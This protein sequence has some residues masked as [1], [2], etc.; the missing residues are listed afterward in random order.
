MKRWN[1]IYDQR[2][3]TLIDETWTENEKIFKNE[4]RVIAQF[5]VSLLSVAKKYIMSEFDTID[6]CI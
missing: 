2:Y 3:E 5:E 4:R 6:L 1:Y